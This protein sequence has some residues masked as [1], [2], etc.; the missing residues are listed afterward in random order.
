MNQP[1]FTII[2]P[3]FNAEKTIQR[4]LESVFGQSYKN[5]EVIII[6]DG[7]ID[8][9]AKK[10]GK[11]LKEKKL[12]NWFYFFQNNQG[13]SIARNKGAQK[14]KGKYLAFLDAD[15][16]WHPKKLEIQYNIITE[17]KCRFSACDYTYDSLEQLNIAKIEI[18]V[19]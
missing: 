3:C 17:H 14:A 8:D 16:E 4:A 6:N 13:P 10:V 12:K 19:L 9:T 15:D 11:F 5:Y 18:E 2:I 1:F 7:S